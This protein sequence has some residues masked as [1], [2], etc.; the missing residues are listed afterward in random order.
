[1]LASRGGETPEA[2]TDILLVED[3]PDDA[4]LTEMALKRRNL[5]NRIVWV[6][7]GAEALDYLFARGAYASRSGL[8]RPGVVLLDLKL[9]KVDGIEVLRAIRANEATRT[10]PVVV[11]TSSTED[12]DRRAAWRTGT[13]SYVSKP[14][15]YEDFQR[16]VEHLGM[17]WLLINQPDADPPGRSGPL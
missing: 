10:L 13:N 11:L 15:G 14:V 3:N 4:E 7:D 6:K 17:Y 8:E 2:Q 5:A 1:M 9:P 16:V 12:T